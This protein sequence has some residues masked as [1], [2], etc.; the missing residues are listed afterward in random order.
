MQ[1]DDYYENV[2]S[3]WLTRNG[4]H[5]ERQEMIPVL[6]EGGKLV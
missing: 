6:T 4:V 5:H 1:R 2:V 3:N